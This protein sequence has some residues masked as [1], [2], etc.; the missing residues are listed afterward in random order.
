MRISSLVLASCM[1]VLAAGSALAQFQKPEDAI[2]RLY[3]YYGIGPNSGQNGI[4]ENKA[5]EVF[6]KSLLALY[7][8][9]ADSGGLDADFFVQG[10]DFSLTKPVEI[11][12]VSVTG[13]RAKVSATLTQGFDEKAGKTLKKNMFVFHLIK[14]NGGWLLDDAYCEGQ[15][16]TSELKADIK[17]GK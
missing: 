12:K 4:D 6:D 1:S 17:Q 2:T 8:R 5:V 10:Q 15:S 11:T 7:K 14:Q 3:S 16:L 13:S 9:A